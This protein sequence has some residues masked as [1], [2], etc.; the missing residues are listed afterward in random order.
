MSIGSLC[1]SAVHVIGFAAAA[2]R[3]RRRP[4]S[5]L[6]GFVIQVLINITVVEETSHESQFNTP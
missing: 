2:W 3:G 1:I 4:L 6:I 5:F